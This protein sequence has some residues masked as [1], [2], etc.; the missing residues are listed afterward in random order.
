MACALAVA[1]VADGVQFMLGPLGWVFADEAIDVGAMVVTTWALGFHILLLPTFVLEFL[2]VTDLLPTWTGCVAV[3]I[4]LRKKS[5]RA[6]T[7][8]NAPPVI[9][10]DPP[11]PDKSVARLP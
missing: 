1:V 3:V 7:S 2:P 10:V 9:S 8:T 4:A 6:V 11:G 5:E